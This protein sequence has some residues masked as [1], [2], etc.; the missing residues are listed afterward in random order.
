MWGV[1]AI[2]S[3]GA[4]GMLLACQASWATP[5][6]YTCVDATGKRLTSD[7][8]IPNCI[9]REQ[10]VLNSDGSVRKT[11]PRTL[12]AEERAEKE[13]RDREALQKQAARQ[14][15]VRR[16]RNL[17][18]RFP[19]EAAHHKAREAA[20][21]DI[22]KAMQTSEARLAALSVER[23]PLEDETEFYIGKPLPAKLKRL[24]DA[25]DAST[26]AQRT[27]IEDQRSELAR[28]NALYDA[29]LNHLKQLWSGAQPGTVGVAPSATVATQP[30]PATRQV[31][32]P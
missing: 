10:R 13:A 23:K 19:N 26:D 32:V 14:D 11:I 25:N 2:R 18:S 12:T 31:K 24:L 29:E 6:I 3:A 7:R 9:D 20:L 5:G 30:A 21:D 1:N 28:I 4:I 15:A 22:R 17:M 27:L 8:P 16:D